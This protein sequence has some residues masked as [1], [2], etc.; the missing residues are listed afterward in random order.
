MTRTSGSR[1]CRA[2]RRCGPLVCTPETIARELS[3][4][5]SVIRLP[6]LELGIVGFSQPMAVFPFMPS[7]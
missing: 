1:R 6:A 3:K 5:L 4:L 7:V 2:R